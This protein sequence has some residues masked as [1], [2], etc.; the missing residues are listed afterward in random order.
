MWR[1]ASHERLTHAGLDVLIAAT[2]FG[3]VV[4]LMRA[5]ATCLRETQIATAQLR[6]PETFLELD[7]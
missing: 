3:A 5:F 7:R 1:T 6:I 2:Y 4:L